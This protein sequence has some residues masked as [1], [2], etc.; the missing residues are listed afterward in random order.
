MDFIYK[1]EMHCHTAG[2]SECASCT[3]E[4]TVEEYLRYGY[5]SL[6]VTDH[7]N[8]CTFSNPRIAGAGDRELAEYFL[9]GYRKTKKAAG[10]KLNILLGAEIRFPGEGGTDYLVYGLD[11]SFYT[12]NI[13][14]YRED[15]YTAG[16]AIH[17]AGGLFFQA[18]P[19]RF[20]MKLCED[21]LIDG[22][23]VYNGHPTQF[24]HNEIAELWCAQFSKFLPISGSDHHDVEQCPDAG[25]LTAEPISSEIGLIETLKSRK[26]RLLRNEGTRQKCMADIMLERGKNIPRD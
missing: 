26:Y 23:E 6:V 10:E 25:I 20:N 8:E 22:V 2:V 13:G 24:S 19:F 11:E 3:P 14:L 15:K 18:H 16:E 9:E 1:T 12:E 7:L 17:K 5:S 4:R 21:W